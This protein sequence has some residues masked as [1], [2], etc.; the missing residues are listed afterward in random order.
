MTFDLFMLVLI[1]IGIAI[2]LGVIVEKELSDRSWRRENYHLD[3]HARRDL[4]H[5]E[6][7][8]RR[9]LNEEQ[10]H[11]KN[12]LAALADLQKRLD[13]AYDLIALLAIL[14][15]RDAHLLVADRDAAITSLTT[16]TERRSNE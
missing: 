9:N 11:L 12:A 13:A 4:R 3:Q 14:T 5:A 6:E 16:E 1:L 10:G 2:T 8:A 7:L 15:H